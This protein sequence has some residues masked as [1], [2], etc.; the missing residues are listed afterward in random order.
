M[1]VW[2]RRFSRVVAGA[3]A[4]AIVA[5]ASIAAAETLDR[6]LAVVSGNLILL[7]DVTA[8]RELGLAAVPAGAADPV[9]A[10]LSALID[11]ELIIAEVN[12]YAPP[13]PSDEAVARALAGVR[14]RFRDDAEYRA[15][16]SRSGV[17]EAYLRRR[18]R[19]DLRIRAYLDQRFT[20]MPP[21][22]ADVDRYYRDHPQAFT[23]D[24]TRL[25]LDA[26][27]EE[28]IRILAGERRKAMI[29]DWV[30]G[31]RR[32]TE[33]TDLYLPER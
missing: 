31:L 1:S 22:D 33:V 14:G 4:C 13:D 29:D 24:G 2:A 12:R 6:V 15:A 27:R 7:S 20:V 3:C 17:D 23:R 19:E 11:R 21:S 9:A 25:P 8:A 26:V 10:V 16:L 32:R 28:V 30:A 5:A 18:L